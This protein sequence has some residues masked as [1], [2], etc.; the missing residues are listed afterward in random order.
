MRNPFQLELEV[1]GEIEIASN[2]NF[3]KVDGNTSN[4]QCR[5]N[6]IVNLGSLELKL[7]VQ[8]HQG[9]INNTNIDF[10]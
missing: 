5:V 3:S 8:V 7:Q 4:L 9:M 10:L 1:N 6:I 2:L